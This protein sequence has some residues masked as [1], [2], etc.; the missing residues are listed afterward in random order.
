MKIVIWLKFN[1]HQYE[2]FRDVNMVMLASNYS[3]KQNK[4]NKQTHKQKTIV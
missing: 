4:T 3:K 1:T 2:T